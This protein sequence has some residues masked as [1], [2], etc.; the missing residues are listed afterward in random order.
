MQ[1]SHKWMNRELLRTHERKSPG[2]GSNLQLYLTL[3]LNYGRI[4]QRHMK[5]VKN[6]SGK[7]WSECVTRYA[8]G[9]S[10]EKPRLTNNNAARS[11]CIAVSS[12]VH[13]ASF[14]NALQHVLFTSVIYTVDL[15][16][17]SRIPSRERTSRLICISSGANI[18]YR[19]YISLSVRFAGHDFSLKNT[20]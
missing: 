13:G 17:F 15:P 4:P 6:L 2:S 16:I 19:C 8:H 1:I 20:Q 12:V 7:L 11:S 14:R 9:V 10:H 5:K 3:K 18:L